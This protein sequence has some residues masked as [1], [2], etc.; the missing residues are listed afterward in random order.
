[1]KRI[2]PSSISDSNSLPS[3]SRIMPRSDWKLKNLHTVMLRPG[4]IIQAIEAEWCPIC[5]SR[6]CISERF[7]NN[8]VV[9]HCDECGYEW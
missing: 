8:A 2:Y 7:S 6:E 9:W 1:M 3:R 5:H 4:S